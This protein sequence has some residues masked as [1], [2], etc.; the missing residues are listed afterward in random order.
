M[1]DVLILGTKFCGVVIII[2]AALAKRSVSS[3]LN[4]V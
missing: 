3:T 2:P 4:S 1:S